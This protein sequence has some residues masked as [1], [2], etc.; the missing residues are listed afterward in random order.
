M[1]RL[2]PP[3]PLKDL[4]LGKKDSCPDGYR[5]TVK[6]FGQTWTIKY[7]KRIRDK[8]GEEL[9]GYSEAGPRE[10]GI[11]TELAPEAMRD[12]LLHEII[13][14]YYR[15]SPCM[16]DGPALPEDSDDAEEALVVLHTSLFIDLV[17]NNKWVRGL[18]GVK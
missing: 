6:I 3:T 11:C 4:E 12:T 9:Y 18:F 15:Q 10:I 1:N 13:H 5:T 17:T 8:D 16:S 7:L 14:S 2:G